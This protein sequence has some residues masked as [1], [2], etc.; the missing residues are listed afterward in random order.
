MLEQLANGDRVLVA[1]GEFGEIRVHGRIELDAPF[2]VQ[3]H[4]GGGRADDL[5]EG[6]EIVDRFGGGDAAAGSSPIDAAEAF[7]PDCGALATDDYC[8]AGKATGLDATTHDAIDGLQ[9]LGR[10]ANGGGC[11]YGQSS[12]DGCDH[13]DHSDQRSEHVSDLTPK[14]RCACCSRRAAGSL[15]RTYL[16]TARDVPAIR[17]EPA[18]NSPIPS[19]GKTRTC[20]SRHSRTL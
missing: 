11:R 20:C 10:H 14:R 2:V 1:A 5:R 9:A 17:C 15:Y 3:D 12:I 4:D 16:R 7:L 19:I 6:G 18:H 8:S 13:G